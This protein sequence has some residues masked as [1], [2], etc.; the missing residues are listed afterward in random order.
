MIEYQNQMIGF[1]KYDRVLVKTLADNAI[2]YV[3]LFDSYNEDKLDYPYRTTDNRNF[4]F[5][6]P[7]EG[8]EEL[9]GTSYNSIEELREATRHNFGDKI[10]VT[11][12]GE[13]Y[14]VLYIAPSKHK[15]KYLAV[16]EPALAQ[17]LGYHLTS[18][19][20]AVSGTV[21]TRGNKDDDE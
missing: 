1:Q 9:I 5:A 4:A 2:W 16:Y 3:A 6:L 14:T 20:R 19:I 15:G 18:S 7:F 13:P 17:K 8:N 11:Y 21:I 12:E 10:E